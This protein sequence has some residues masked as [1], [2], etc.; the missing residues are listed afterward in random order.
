[1][2]ALA[3]AA[4]RVTYARED[5]H[6]FA[7]VGPGTLAGRYPRWARDAVAE[8]VGAELQAFAEG[9]PRT[10]WTRPPGLIATS[11]A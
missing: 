1:M 6:D 4:D 11:G 8:A 3:E 2:M 7:H 10:L 9:R 5:Y